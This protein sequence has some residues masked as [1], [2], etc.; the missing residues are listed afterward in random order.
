MNR[1]EIIEVFKTHDDEYASFDKI[2][3]KLSSRPDIHAFILLNL[4]V[5]GKTD[6]IT[7]S[8]HDE[9]YLDVEIDELVEENATKNQII[10]LIRCGVI[11]EDEDYL[12][13]MV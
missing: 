2:K 11:L 8:G 9:I 7:S 6:M 10:D 4:M 3:G 1:E 13:M 5:P 12:L